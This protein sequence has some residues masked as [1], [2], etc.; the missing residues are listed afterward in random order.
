ME[1]GTSD[2]TSQQPLGPDFTYIKDVK[3]ERKGWGC[4][5]VT[6]NLPSMCHG[7]FTL[8]HKRKR[9]RRREKEKKAYG[10]GKYKT[11]KQV[12]KEMER[13]PE[14]MLKV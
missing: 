8:L 13:S 9:E 1:R 14:D 2:S 4:W 6:E 7:S 11:S 10:E 3:R 12:F 5:L